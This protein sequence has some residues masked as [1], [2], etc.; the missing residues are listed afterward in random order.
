MLFI[1]QE[2]KEKL[3]K[4]EDENKQLEAENN[5]LERELLEK[6]PVTQKLSLNWWSIGALVLALIYIIYL[7]V[8][9]VG[10]S[11]QTVTKDDADFEATILRDGKIEKWNA[12]SDLE[13]V[14]RV[15]LGAYENFDL[16]SVAQNL[17]GL[18]QDSIDGFKK[19]SLGAFSRLRDAQ[20]FLQKMEQL[21][22]PN[23]YIVA[24]K[25]NNP[26]GLIEAQRAETKTTN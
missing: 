25:N 24:Y 5:R 20:V 12:G 4:L 11:S 19:V 26:I 15:Q 13:I 7:H 8:A 16:S 6:Q 9:V 23:I 10:S 21:K 2:I 18:H 3:A 17:D 22:L 14:Y 1:P